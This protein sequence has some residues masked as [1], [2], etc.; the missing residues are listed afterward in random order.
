VWTAGFDPLRDE[1]ARYAERLQEAGVDCAYHCVD[2]QVHGF[3]S[4]GV[5]PGGM[6]RVAGI[7]RGAGELVGA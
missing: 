3:F 2:D 5:L 1:G 7:C 4:M 6:A